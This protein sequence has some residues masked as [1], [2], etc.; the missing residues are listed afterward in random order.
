MLKKPCTIHCQELSE[1]FSLR[2]RLAY[3][4]IK[5]KVYTQQQL[6]DVAVKHYSGQVN[7]LYQNS[8]LV[9]IRNSNWTEWSTIQEVIRRELSKLVVNEVQLL[10]NRT[11]IQFTKSSNWTP[12]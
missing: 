11:G 7:E 5:D 2:C 3:F 4:E 12:T 10:I 6:K 1:F 8:N 9:L